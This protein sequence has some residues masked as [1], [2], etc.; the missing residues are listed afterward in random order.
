MGQLSFSARHLLG[1]TILLMLGLMDYAAGQI[2]NP[3]DTIREQRPTHTAG[4][5]P[6]RHHRARAGPAAAVVRNAGGHRRRP[7]AGGVG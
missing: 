3:A 1:F 7:A 4:N 5:A 6:E 2:V